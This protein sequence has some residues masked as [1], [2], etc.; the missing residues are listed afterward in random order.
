MKI[1]W[2]VQEAP[3]G[4]YK[5]FQQRG[6]PMAVFMPG[7]HYAATLQCNDDYTPAAGRGDKPHAP[8]VIT[9]ADHNTPNKHGGLRTLKFTERATTLAEA[10][11]RIKR[12]YKENPHME[13]KE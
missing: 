1:V 13:P 12:F 5:S 10:K 11:Q 6:W 4:T 7:D 9:V 8:L 2:K 3:T